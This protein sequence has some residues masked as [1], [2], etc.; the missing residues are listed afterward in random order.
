MPK[1]EFKLIGGSVVE[2]YSAPTGTHWRLSIAGGDTLDLRRADFPQ[3]HTVRF[4][5]ANLLGGCRIRVP[6]GTNVDIGGLV[7]VGGNH[8]KVEPGD[9]ETNN[10]ISIRFYGLAGGVSVESD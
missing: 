4:R 6:K 10:S 7:L 1:I 3:D 9:G 2:S 5:I 8:S